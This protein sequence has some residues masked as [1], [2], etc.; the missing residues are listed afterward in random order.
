[1]NNYFGEYIDPDGYTSIINNPNIDTDDI[2]MLLFSIDY[3]FLY[4][5]FSNPKA[6]KYIPSIN[7]YIDNKCDLTDFMSNPNFTEDLLNQVIDTYIENDIF[8]KYPGKY[9]ETDKIKHI[10]K[11]PNLSLKYF[12]K[13][14]NYIIPKNYRLLCK[15]EWS[16]IFN[17]PNISIKYLKKLFKTS[18]EFYESF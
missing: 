18:D 9:S 5:I 2:D 4:V 12:K 16:S 13:L 10:T 7:T 6:F 15:V 17:N 14:I 3:C 11:N 1:M 8:I